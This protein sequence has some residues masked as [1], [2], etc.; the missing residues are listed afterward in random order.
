MKE[1]LEYTNKLISLTSDA[2]E[3]FLNAFEL[4]VFPKGAFIL[5]AD[6]TCKHFYFIKSGLTKSHFYKEDKEFIMTF[7]R[8]NSM[9][10]E[11]NSYLTERPS[12]YMILALEE[13]TVYRISKNDLLAL[14]KQYHSI[15][16]L[17]SKL[18]QLATLG[19]MKRISEMLEENATEGYNNFLARNSG[20]MQRI[21]LGDLS[22]YLGIT[23]VSLSRIRAGK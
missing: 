12:K 11:M 9:F 1:I 22:N 18:F 8:E 14:C 7:F 5:R 19:M 15:E 16:A 2:S 4:K 23:Q 10:T 6:Q 21:S 20:L 13:T 17:Y 3:A